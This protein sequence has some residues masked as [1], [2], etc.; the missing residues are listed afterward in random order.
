MLRQSLVTRPSL[1][2]LRLLGKRSP[3]HGHFQ[4]S[5]TSTRPRLPWR[6]VRV[7]WRPP[8]NH[9]S[10]K[11]LKACQGRTFSVSSWPL[12]GGTTTTRRYQSKLSAVSLSVSVMRKHSAWEM[13]VARRATSAVLF[14]QLS[15]LFPSIPEQR[16]CRASTLDFLFPKQAARNLPGGTSRHGTGT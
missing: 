10:V 15:P 8:L 3:V 16:V 5:V 11:R 4:A 14:D 9:Q 12:F 6:F 7:T 13:I 1:E 2:S